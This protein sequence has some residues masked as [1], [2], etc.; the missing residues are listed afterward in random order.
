[1]TQIVLKQLCREYDIDPYK[2]RVALRDKVGKAPEGSWRWQNEKDPHLK[3]C[4][5]VLS[6][7]S[8]ATKAKGNTEQ[9]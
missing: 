9:T 8:S 5:E 3:K 2:A 1:M 7:M 6:S 4:R